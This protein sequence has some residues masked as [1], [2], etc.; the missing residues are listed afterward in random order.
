MAHRR[1]TEEELLQIQNLMLNHH[2][3]KISFGL[4][5]KSTEIF[6]TEEENISSLSDGELIHIAKQMG[7]E[8][9][10]VID[11]DGGLAN[12][13]EVVKAIKEADEE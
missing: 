12:T 7:M 6:I 4:G 1:P 3:K 10:L 11:G 5:N 8:D 13:E 9:L 2:N